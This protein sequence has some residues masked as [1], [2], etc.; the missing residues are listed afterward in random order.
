[1]K[2]SIFLTALLAVSLTGFSQ[3]TVHHGKGLNKPADAWKTAKFKAPM[4]RS[5][6][7]K[8]P[9][10]ASV[11][12]WSPVPASQGETGTCVAWASTYCA[13]TIC[14]A[15]SHGVTNRATIT[16]NA[17]LPAFT[18]Y[19]IKDRGDNNCQNG[20]WGGAACE[21][22]EKTGAVPY[23]KSS[24]KCC[25]QSVPA[26][27]KN[28]AKDNKITSYA[29]LFEAQNKYGVKSRVEMVKKEISQG[30][31]VI[32]GMMLP[33]SFMN[34]RAFTS[35]GLYKPTENL[36][37]YRDDGGHEMCIVAYDDNK[38]GGAFL[39]QNSWGTSWGYKGYCWITYDTFIW[40]VDD[41]HVLYAP[42]ASA[43]NNSVDLTTSKLDFS[44]SGGD[45]GCD[46]GSY[47]NGGGYDD[48]GDYYDYDDGYNYIVDDGNDDDSYYYDYDYNDDAYDDYNQYYAD[49]DNGAWD[50]YDDY[51]Y[52]YDGDNGGYD[53]Y[54][55]YYDDDDYSGYDDYGYNDYYGG[56]DDDGGYYDDYDDYDYYDDGDYCYSYSR[57]ITI[58][59]DT[60]NVFRFGGNLKL[61][62]SDKTAMKGSCKGNVIEMDGEYKS[63]TEFRVYIGNNQPA[64]VYVFGTDLSNKMYNIFPRNKNI[65]PYL[66]ANSRIAFPNEEMWLEMDNNAGTDYL[67]IIYS[68]VPVNVPLVMQKMTETPG[69]FETKIFDI[70]GPKAFSL[71]DTK[72]SG[73]EVFKFNTQ[74]SGK[75]TMVAI[76]KFKHVN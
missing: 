5:V 50:Y 40:T 38:F 70:L 46:S 73:N 19:N 58:K 76:I 8:L 41:A 30:H 31:P 25:L 3:Q 13:A 57:G 54:E 9:A 62:K 75:E 61:V 65:S 72:F 10:A 27:L 22:L 42:I 67:Y 28:L 49:D 32:F 17:M 44:T 74:V 1:M 24:E 51:S 15:Q 20:S 68:L 11:Q 4:A 7:E 6:Y 33:A 59:G 16:K 69:K 12:K 39:V 45:N 18:Y 47:D 71:K 36:Q 14:W 55:D 21:F 60:V 2:K 66:D 64:Y 35:E 29:Q 48:G 53:Y 43:T 56:Y 23:A 63:G 37:S 26:D 34:D 52:D